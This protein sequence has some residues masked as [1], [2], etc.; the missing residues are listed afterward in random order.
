[1][2]PLE[3]NKRWT[4]VSW[5][6]L[7]L[8]S[9]GPVVQ[10]VLSSSLISAGV[11]TR[12]FLRT[13]CFGRVGRPQFIPKIS[14]YSKNGKRPAISNQAGAKC[15]CG[16]LM[17]CFAGSCCSGSHSPVKLGFWF[18]GAGSQPTSTTESEQN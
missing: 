16:D 5:S 12:V 17:V 14:L 2:A 18:G 1:M 8:R 10:T 6:K 9:P 4:F 15:G 7:F 11:S 13:N 3:L